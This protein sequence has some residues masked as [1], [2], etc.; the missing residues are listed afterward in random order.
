LV[1]PLVFFFWTAAEQ[2]GAGHCLDAILNPF[3]MELQLESEGRGDGSTM[4]KMNNAALPHSYRVN[5][6]VPKTR[7]TNA[8]LARFSPR[9]IAPKS[10]VA[11]TASQEHKVNEEPLWE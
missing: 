5:S 4:A 11:T 10:D 8:V 9:V 6:P 1:L 3:S 2:G 7:G